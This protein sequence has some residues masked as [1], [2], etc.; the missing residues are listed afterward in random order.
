MPNTSHKI[1]VVPERVKRIIYDSIK[2]IAFRHNGI[3]FG[4][5]VRDEIIS[6][7]YTKL[8]IEGPNSVKQFWDTSFSPET[9][10]RTLNAED[11]DVCFHDD[12]DATAFIKNVVERIEYKTKNAFEY[13]NEELI[14]THIYGLSFTNSIRSV[15]R[16]TF[17]MKLGM[18]PWLYSGIDLTISIDVVMT[19]NPKL[20]PPFNNLDFLC[21][22]FIMTKHGRLLST[23]TGTNIDRMTELARSKIS[24]QIIGDIINFKTDFCMGQRAT[25][26]SSGTF[27]YNKYAFKRIDKLLTK[28]LG[29]HI[30]N[31]PFS[32]HRPTEQC[33]T[34]DD[35]NADVDSCCI[36]C[37]DFQDINDMKIVT[38]L[39][40]KGSKTRSSVLHYKCLSLYIQN[41]IVEREESDEDVANEFTFICPYRNPI[42]LLNTA[43]TSKDIILKYAGVL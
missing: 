29:W 23:C 40:N 24:T 15:R 6:E 33:P 16:L 19:Y 43:K 1:E 7:H 5:F 26:C 38:Y 32:I 35:K 10:A 27:K 37:C 17:N 12:N 21:N 8:Y 4:G 41:Q 39:C 20:L 22:A 31:L 30:N 9:K 28:E 14:N 13:T 11:M 34:N 36:C 18:I 3:I 2:R 42:N 25:L